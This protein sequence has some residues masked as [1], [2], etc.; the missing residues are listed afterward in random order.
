[1]TTLTEYTVTA[2]ETIRAV[3]PDAKIVWAYGMG[4]TSVQSR[5]IRNS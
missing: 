5:I 3:H 4:G 2:L 1:M